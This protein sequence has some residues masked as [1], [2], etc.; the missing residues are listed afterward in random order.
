MR[1]SFFR[2]LSSIFQI[3][4]S[5]RHCEMISIKFMFMNTSTFVSF[6][7]FHYVVVQLIFIQM[8]VGNKMVSLQLEEIEKAMQSI[9]S[10]THA[11][12]MLM[13]IKL[14]MLLTMRMTE[15]CVG[16]KEPHME[17][18]LQVETVEEDNGTYSIYSF[19]VIMMG[20]HIS[21]FCAEVNNGLVRL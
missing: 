20:T 10:R 21:M 7:S 11:V 6:Q 19:T 2:K 3:N 8:L 9:N 16:Q 15:S 1:S 13:M 5:A 14:P 17:V 18:S 12:C 4:H